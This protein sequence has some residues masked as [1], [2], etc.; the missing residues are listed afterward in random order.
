MHDCPTGAPK[1]SCGS[2]P[3]NGTCH[4]AVSSG[5][6]LQRG[7]LGAV[8]TE[9]QFHQRNLKCWMVTPMNKAKSPHHEPDRGCIA[10]QP[11][12]V[13]MCCGWLSAFVMREDESFSNFSLL[14]GRA[15]VGPV[16]VGIARIADFVAFLKCK[17]IVFEIGGVAVEKG[18]V[19]AGFVAA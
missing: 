1:I 11:Q 13:R 14:R 7:E 3:K 5:F 12:Q 6:P 8:S 16:D 17:I 18:Q 2:L 4:D 15:V 10:D 19:R 9:G